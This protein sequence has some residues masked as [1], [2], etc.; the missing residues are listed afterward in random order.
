LLLFAGGAVVFGSA[1]A[2]MDQLATQKP[3]VG[4]P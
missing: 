3:Y 1:L 2:I 4:K